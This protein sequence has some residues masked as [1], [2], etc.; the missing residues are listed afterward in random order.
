MITTEIGTASNI[1]SRT[2]RLCVLSALTHAQQKLK[3]YNTIP[4]LGLAIFCGADEHGKKLSLALDDLTAH[5][6]DRFIYKC[7]NIFHVSALAKLLLKETESY[8]F[9][10]IDGHGVLLATL[11][12]N[13]VKVIANVQVD[14]PKKHGR[15][16]QSK[17]RFDRIRLEKRH[18]YITKISELVTQ[19][20]LD[21]DTNAANVKG[22]VVAGSADLKTEFVESP[23]FDPRVKRA[24]VAVHDIAYGG[25]NG[26]R[27]AINM[28]IDVFQSSHFTQEQAI[29][30]KL[31]DTL[32]SDCREDIIVVGQTDVLQCLEAG[33]L[34]MI[35]VWDDLATIHADGQL[36]VEWLADRA[37][38]CGASF[39][40]VSNASQE[41]TQFQKGFGGL[42]GIA[43]YPVTDIINNDHDQANNENESDEDIF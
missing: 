26:L 29:L 42:V 20:F 10:I 18:N 2:N 22:L 25:H 34:E 28:S 30:R 35:I 38:K 41:G 1:K 40:V 31:F 14:L 23:L 43:R 9:V 3:Q 11:V 33:A 27:Q 39:N 4:P 15:G 36:L 21:D 19:H 13:N 7:D 17:V 6:I 37:P 8:G 12:G 16:G 32:A 24:L 5:P